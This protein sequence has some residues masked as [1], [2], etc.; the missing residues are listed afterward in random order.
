MI[1]AFTFGKGIIDHMEDCIQS[2]EEHLFN[3]PTQIGVNKIISFPP[4]CGTNGEILE[5]GVMTIEMGL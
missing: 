5:I 2:R 3:H 1:N 4:T